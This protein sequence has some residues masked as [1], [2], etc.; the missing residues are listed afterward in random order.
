VTQ[1][2]IRDLAALPPADPVRLRPRIVVAPNDQMFHLAQLF[3]SLGRMTRP[4]LHVVRDLRQAFAL[5]R[6]TKPHFEPIE[7]G[8]LLDPI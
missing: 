2:G 5:L 1:Q 4:N 6:V 8:G 3:Q 7:P